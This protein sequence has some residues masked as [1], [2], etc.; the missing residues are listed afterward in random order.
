MSGQLRV[1]IVDDSELMRR[2]L[3]GLIE[4][5]PELLVVGT[6]AD[7][8]EAIT[9]VA[10][11]HP[12]IITMDVRMPNLDGL[13]ATEYL[14][15]YHPT[16][17]LVLTASLSR[18]DVDIT[19]KMLAAGALDV[20]EK[21]RLSDDP[22]LVRARS[23]LLRRLK[24]LA[25]V[26]VVTHLRGRRLAQ[27]TATPPAT[28]ASDTLGL[29][30]PVRPRRLMREP[31][32]V[33]GAS[34]GGPRVLQQILSTMPHD[35]GAPLL[36]V[37]H[38]A[39]HFVGGLIEWLGATST[40]PVRLACAGEPLL[41]GVV[42]VAPERRDLLLGPDDTVALGREARQ[43]HASIDCSMTAVAER[44]GRRAIGVLLTGMGSD[45]AAGLLAIRA[46]GGH[47]IAQS[48]ESCVVWGMPRAA[49]ER[50]AAA[51]VLAPE[52]VVAALRRLVPRARA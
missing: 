7:G 27:S 18:H 31:V 5:D 25:R 11:L 19:F 24:L 4:S 12:D 43:G 17:I 36:V 6:A 34:T 10:Q 14:M 47:T 20:I 16:P 49:I 23:E 46:A 42:L 39:D 45:G 32:V 35:F 51:E 28:A 30:L 40:L 13:A 29:A 15:A 41:P 50:N 9:L 1:L 2:V 21:P 38:I 44:Y 33:I 48:Q 37:Q 26:Q 3:Q 52:G 22:G 8:R